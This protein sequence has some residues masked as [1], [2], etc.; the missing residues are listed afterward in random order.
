M[1]KRKP[2]F[3]LIE[4]LIVIAIIAILAAL[5]LPALNA[6]RESGLSTTCINRLRQVGY[7]AMCYAGDNNDIIFAPDSKHLLSSNPTTGASWHNL[8]LAPYLKIKVDWKKRAQ[9]PLA[10]PHPRALQNSSGL[11]PG[12][13]MYTYQ[14]RPYA[15]IKLGVPCTQYSYISGAVSGVLYWKNISSMILFGDTGT[16][17][18]DMEKR[19]NQSFCLDTTT[20]GNPSGY[21]IERHRGRGNLCYLDGHVGSIRGQQLEDEHRPRNQWPWYD[22]NGNGLGTAY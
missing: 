8:V 16:V 21:F 4:L 22:I 15:V 17:S 13:G 1:K 19:Q 7:F 12:Y 20:S 10:C 3:T 5:L 9:Y 14:R 6:A 11:F 18:S 2:D